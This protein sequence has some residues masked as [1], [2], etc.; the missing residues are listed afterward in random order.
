MGQ[1]ISKQASLLES[2]PLVAVHAGL[3]VAFIF[4]SLLGPAEHAG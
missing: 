2:L 3:T 4:Y 1:K